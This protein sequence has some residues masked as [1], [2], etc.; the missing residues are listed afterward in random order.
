LPTV[1]TLNLRPSR[2]KNIPALTGLRGAAAMWVVF[3]HIAYHVPVP[4]IRFGYLGVDVFFILSGFVL[5]YVYAGDLNPYD[6]RS[7]LRFLQARIARIYP[8]H[9]VTLCALGVIVLSFPDFA[10]RYTMPAQ[11]WGLGPFLASMFLIQ[12]WAHWLPTCWNTPAWSLSAEYFGYIVFPIFL[13][14]T[15]RWQGRVMPLILALGS[16]IL[17][18]LILMAHGI[19]GIGVTGTPGMLRMAFELA[20]GCLLYRAMANG[21]PILPWTGRLDSSQSLVLCVVIS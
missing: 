3:Y 14:I 4:I 9:A 5:S 10:T 7:Y 21:L 8:L 20:C 19:H 16:L 12:N 13:G 2:A 15:Q 6:F 18:Y 17:F 1:G 11:R